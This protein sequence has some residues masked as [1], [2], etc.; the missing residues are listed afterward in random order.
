M[1]TRL[2]N[3]WELAK[4]SWRV[5]LADKEL[6]VFPIISFFASMLVFATFIVPML[7]T[8]M[9]E[10]L[11]GSGLS[12]LGIIV[13]LAYYSA[14]YF[15]TI[16]ANS[17]LV[18]AAMIRLEGGDPTVGDGLRIAFKHIGS[19]FSYAV[20]AATVGLILNQISERSG[21]F[22]KIVVGII[23]FAWNVATFLVVPV[24]VV[25][26]LGPIEAIKRSGALLKRTWGEQIAGNLSVGFVFGLIGFLVFLVGAVS[27]FLAFSL[28]TVL[29][30]TVVALFA[31]L[32]V[33]VSLISS[34]L[35]GIYKAAVYQYA[36]SGKSGGFFDQATIENAFKRR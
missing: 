13:G 31:A 17:A 29:G 10:S 16:F 2:T 1:F 18:G 25:E 27:S 20:I 12:V 24:L 19:I 6:L 8:N 30:I 21:Q 11:F 15:V 28:S 36:I 14:L 35:S 7:L 3:S 33:I 9:L 34:T 5:L 22:G 4:A 26:G 23:G 32:L